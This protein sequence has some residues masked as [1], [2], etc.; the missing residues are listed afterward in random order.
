MKLIGLTGGVGSG[1]STVSAMLAAK[2]A[3]IVD[4]DLITRRLQQ[5]GQPIFAAIL[6]RFG[7]LVVDESGGLDRAALAE[8]VFAD[9]AALADLEAIV[10]PAV[11]AEIA[12]R[13]AAEQETDHVVVLDVPLL[14]EKSSY[15]IDGLVVVDTPPEQAVERLLAQRGMSEA[16]VKARMANQADREERI[17][18]ANV[19]I[20]N[21]A[22]RGHLEAEVD[23]VWAW[24]KS[25][26]V[27]AR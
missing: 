12:S 5:P 1:K 23:R 6:R 11:A 20:D 22:D 17:A 10:H 21:G 19:V 18:R 13:I 2:G 8:I 7:S 27:T 14:V 25:P 4:A 3:V 26:S 9:K 16:D 15:P 24:A